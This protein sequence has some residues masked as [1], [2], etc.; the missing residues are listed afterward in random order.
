MNCPFIGAGQFIIEGFSWLGYQ[1]FYFQMSNLFAFHLFLVPL[2]HE[3]KNMMFR[4]F[5][6]EQISNYLSII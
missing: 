4:L 1:C 3:V 5:S 6:L 2:N